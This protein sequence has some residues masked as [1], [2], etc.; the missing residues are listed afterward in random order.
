MSRYV[1]E[2]PQEDLTRTDVAQP[3]LFAVS[4]ALAEVA[5]DCGL[6]PDLVTGHSLGEYTAAAVSR[7]ARPRR[8]DAARVRAAGG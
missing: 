7:G 5:A 4:L 1:A 3:A 2:G 8:R 6:A